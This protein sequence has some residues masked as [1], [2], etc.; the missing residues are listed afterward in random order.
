MGIVLITIFLF[1]GL[2]H[3]LLTIL[4]PKAKIVIDVADDD[5]DLESIDDTSYSHDDPLYSTPC[6][7]LMCCKERSFHA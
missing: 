4:Q 5:A 3:P 1:G 7:F 6:E 2:T